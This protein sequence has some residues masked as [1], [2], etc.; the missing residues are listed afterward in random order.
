MQPS[1]SHSHEHRFVFRGFDQSV[2]RVLGAD[3]RLLYG[4]L[5]PILMIVGLIV[6]LGLSPAA[7]LVAVIVG[8]EIAALLLVVRGLL[9]MMSDDQDDESQSLS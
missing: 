4:M 8:F 6:V 9:E 5:V 1:P 3:A 7:W 2:E